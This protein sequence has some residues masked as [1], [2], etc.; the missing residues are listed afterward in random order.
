MDKALLFNEREPVL[1]T[2]E[3]ILDGK[4]PRDSEFVDVEY[5]D[6]KVK[7]ICAGKPMA[8]EEVGKP[9]FR[10]YYS[11]EEYKRLYPDRADKYAIVANMRRFQESQWHREWKDKLSSFCETEKYFKTGS[12]W[13]FADAYNEEHDTCVE[14]QHSYASSE[15]EDR[16]KFY[17]SLN[18]KIIWLFHLPKAK[19][20]EGDDGM[21]EILEDNAR[22]F[23]RAAYESQDKFSNACVFIQTKS[24]H[25]YRVMELFRRKGEW[26]DHVATVRYFEPTG[27]W[28]EEEWI[29]DLR[30]GRLLNTEHIATN[31]T[32]N[33]HNS[34]QAYS[35]NELWRK[36]YKCMEVY[37]K[38]DGKAI[39]VFRDKNTGRISRDYESGCISYQ[40]AGYTKKFY[41]MSY[42]KEREKV[43]RFIKARD[44][45][46]EWINS[47]DKK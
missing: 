12:R 47:Q 7:F 13:K 14:L 29:E 30:R 44:L 20:R 31:G 42:E 23:F 4:Y 40:Y 6:Y 37:N 33:D 46:G 43:W 22:G 24:K 35:I 41:T 28:T 45:N 38:N 9:Y 19:V 16:N 27:K 36:N 1:V 5:P 18:K 3:D 34:D 25:I 10:L 32:A 21:Y 11:Y 26:D 17:S 8:G 2:A 39:F 15:F